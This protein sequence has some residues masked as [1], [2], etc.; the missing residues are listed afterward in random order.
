MKA[1]LGDCTRYM[2]EMGQALLSNLHSLFYLH[3]MLSSFWLDSQSVPDVH[4]YRAVGKLMPAL[5]RPK[6]AY[7]EM[8]DSVSQLV[9]LLW[10]Q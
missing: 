6:M 10:M 5:Q 2:A 9:C 1:V 3:I 4:L 7:L 8:G